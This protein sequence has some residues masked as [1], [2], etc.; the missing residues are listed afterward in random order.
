MRMMI[1]T[2]PLPSRGFSTKFSNADC[3][4]T[5]DWCAWLVGAGS[6]LKQA[7][8]NVPGSFS[9]LMTGLALPLD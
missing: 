9:N 1:F 5:S 2:D 3:T 8:Y 6:D 4:R 7:S